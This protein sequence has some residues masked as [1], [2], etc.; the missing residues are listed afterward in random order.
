MHLRLLSHFRRKPVEVNDQLSLVIPSPSHFEEWCELRHRSRSFLEPWEPKW[1]EDDLTKIGYR[2]RLNSYQKQ[3]STGLGRT[4]FLI[5]SMSGKLMGGLSLSKISH[6]SFRSATLGYWMGVD[7]A[8]K[9]HM[10]DAVHGI[11]RHAF[12]DLALNRVEAA[13]I[14]GNSRSIHLLQKCGFR[15]E[16][17]AR[18]YLEINGIREDHILFAVLRADR[19][20]GN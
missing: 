7:H 2:R 15:K 5:D 17:F 8:G 14:P 10:Q 16:G 12:S 1:P 19:V 13:C 3:R 20:I 18:E 6:G 9:G 11:L 4:Y